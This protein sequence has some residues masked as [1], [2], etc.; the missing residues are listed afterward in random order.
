MAHFAPIRPLDAGQNIPTPGVLR[1]RI[2]Q[3]LLRLLPSLLDPA[4]TVLLPDW[5]YRTWYWSLECPDLGER[6]HAA[7]KDRG[8]RRIA[9]LSDPRVA[10]LVELVGGLPILDLSAAIAA[11]LVVVREAQVRGSV[12]VG[13]V[14]DIAL[15]I[16]TEVAAARPPR[17]RPSRQHEQF[18]DMDRFAEPE[19]GRVAPEDPR[20]AA[21]VRH[22]LDLP[23][24]ELD[25]AMT[26]QIEGAVMQAREW[27]YRHAAP[28]P[29]LV[30]GHGVP[31]VVPARKLRGPDRL[32]AAVS[33]TTLLGLVA[34]PHPGRG[35]PCQ[36]AWRRGLTYWVAVEFCMGPHAPAPPAETVRWWR[37]QL[38]A[39]A[40]ANP[41]TLLQLSMATRKSLREA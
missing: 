7:T 22:L 38:T 11:A 27:W 9:V 39:A 17:S 6:P 31:G 37:S 1:N 5:S 21:A 24:L 20:I 25:P 14:E 34:G 10:E 16:V 33:C 15:R 41:E 12:D 30:G 18:A 3:R 35:R 19:Q 29:A 4:A 8:L 36:V 26:A 28:V 32:A 23:G 2:M 13:I 40:Q